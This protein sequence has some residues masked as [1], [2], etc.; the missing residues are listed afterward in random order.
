[1]RRGYDA[2][3]DVAERLRFESL[4]SNLAAGFVNLEPERVDYAIEDLSH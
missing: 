1:M 4:V 2:A 3:A